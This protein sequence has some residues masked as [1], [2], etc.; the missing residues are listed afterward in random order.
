[1]RPKVAAALILAAVCIIGAALFIPRLFTPGTNAN[2]PANRDLPQTATGFL[3]GKKA[4]E[5]NFPTPTPPV[6]AHSDGTRP[7]ATPSGVKDQ[8]E[9]AQARQR[10]AEL[11][12]LAMNNDSNSF[13]AIWGELFNKDKA[14]RAGAL[15]ALVQFGDR[16]AVPRLRDLADRTAD[17]DEKA[18]IL[19]AADYLE[20]PTLDELSARQ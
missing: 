6:I 16:S 8:D 11:M 17:P 1:M 15:E 12:A 19:S 20:L 13:N 10:V 2:A 9:T 3:P 18:S 7:T 5:N 4:P 14:I